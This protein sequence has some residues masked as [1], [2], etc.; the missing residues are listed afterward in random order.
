MSGEEIGAKIGSP[1][2]L[3]ENAESTTSQNNSN[4]AVSG[5]VSCKIFH[6]N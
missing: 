4:S 5:S 3:P 6:Y 2:A 1:V